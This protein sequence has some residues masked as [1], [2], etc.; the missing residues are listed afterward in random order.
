M[1]VENII[2]EQV[3]QAIETI[4]DDPN[5]K[6]I[7]DKNG[8]EHHDNIKREIL[9]QVNNNLQVRKSTKIRATN[10]KT[11]LGNPVTH[12]ATGNT[13]Q[14]VTKKHDQSSE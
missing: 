1:H 14:K 6:T 13:V 11:R 9:E 7:I 5:K 4:H 8:N 12:S 2:E 10:P 3:Q